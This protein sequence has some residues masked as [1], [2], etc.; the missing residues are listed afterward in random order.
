MAT[1]LNDLRLTELAT[2]EG[3]GTWGT[4]TNLSLELIGEALGYATQQVFG[5]DADATTT[6]ADGASDPARAMYFKITSAGSLTATRTCTIAPNTISRVMFIENATTGSQSIQI[7]Q[8]SGAS[9][10]ILA[11]KTAVVY[12]DG[13]GSG[14][15]VVDAMAGVDP[16]VT[17][18]LAEVLAAGN[19]SGANNLI[20]D[21][22]QAITTNTI[23]ET[24]AASGVTI[25]SVLLK[26][27]GV[28]ATNLEITNFKANDG[29]SAGSIAD[30]TGVVTLAS[31]V[32]TTADINGGTIDGTTIGATT[33]ASVAAT[34]LST[35]GIATFGGNVTGKNATF[36]TTTAASLITIGDAA[37]GTYSLLRMYGGSGKYNF[38]V[39]VQNNVNNAFEITPSTAVGGTTFTTPALLI[40]GTTGA[41]TFSSTLSVGNIATFTNDNQYLVFNR[42]T[43]GDFAYIGT[44]S[45]TTGG[46]AT[47]LGIRAENNLILGAGGYGADLTIASTGAATFSGNVVGLT[48]ESSVSSSSTNLATNSGGSLTLKNTSV[49]DGNFSN[50]GGYNSNTLVTSQ[51]NF[52]NVSQ[53]SRTGAITFNVHNGT[54]MPEVGRFDASG[55]LGIGTDSPTY[56]LNVLSDAGAQN[57]FQA[58]QSGVSNG[59][60]ITS[61]GSALTYSFLTG[62]VGIGTAAP[63]SI[64]HIKDSGNVSTTLQIEGAATGYAPVINF[65]GIVAGNADYLLGEINGSWDTHTNVVSAI[66]FESGADTTNKDDGLISFWTSSS[67]PTLE[68]RARLTSDGN[69]LVGTTSA[70]GSGASSGKQLIQFNGAA[71]NALY[72]DDTRTAAGTDTAIIFGRGATITGSITTTLTTTAYVTSSDQRLKSQFAPTT[73]A[74]AKIVE[75]HDNQLIGEFHFLSDPDTTVWGYNAHALIDNQPGFGGTE[76]AGPRDM[77]IGEEYEPAT[78]DEDGNEITPAKKVTP[79]GVDQSKRVPLLEAAIYDLLKMNEALTARLDAAGL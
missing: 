47:D 2:G 75:A 34:T 65:D 71:E 67:G 23:N 39:G 45:N 66:R 9:V 30:S 50:I 25:D 44:A 24:T 26:D 64:V 8:G 27:D 28:N 51:I 33:P 49:T 48:F 53:A 12:L 79:A 37:A 60:S 62:N 20:I 68:E 15:A 1:Y 55:N 17:D 35:T 10:T 59:L 13:A 42:P 70:T 69:F 77:A 31:S 43:T 19:T 41:A 56:K 11:G 78:F 14:A 4:T 57:I 32:L 7:S 54:S 40:D 16:G 3:S 73:G 72:V 5:S 76:G 22:G 38:Q 61:D 21:N 46:P 52:V 18:T 58:G 6:I 74:L 36:V 63:E 29:T